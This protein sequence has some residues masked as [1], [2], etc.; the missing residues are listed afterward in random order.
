M[1]LYS[2]QRSRIGRKIKMS[3]MDF[4]ARLIPLQKGGK[5]PAR[6]FANH[7]FTKDEINNFIRHGYNVGLLAQPKFIF[8]DID[9][10]ENHKVDG[11]TNFANWCDDNEIDFES[12]LEKTLVQKT[13]TGGVHMIFLKPDGYDFH[14]DIGFI[15]GVDIKASRNNYIVI[16][17]SKTADGKYEF[18]D[19]KQ[20][21]AILPAT[22]AKAIQKRSKA[23][24]RLQ[25]QVV[26]GEETETGLMYRNTYTKYPVL[27]VFYTMKNGF[28]NKG[29]RNDN[30]FK[31]SQQIRKL[32]D[33]E[34]ALE[35]AKIANEH[36]QVPI[37][38]E[39]LQHTIDS[40]FS[41][42]E[43][44]EE[45]TTKENGKSWVKVQSKMSTDH[46]AVLKSRYDEV[47]SRWKKDY[48]PGDLYLYGSEWKDAPS[49][50]YHTVYNY[51]D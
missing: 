6:K 45:F 46:Y 51:H 22:L 34:T 31:W 42:A 24:R 20:N 44:V 38:S 43:E 19:P 28:G 12:L 48:D 37:N 11:I 16:A 8:I 14:Q 32:T 23:Q 27:D 25:Q 9:T 4:G 17:P 49:F 26:T 33:K 1:D 39:E 2:K 47:G 21:P 29:T 15:D 36:T 3:L 13:P 30:L 50:K 10:P 41:F 7:D 40:A 5:R 35:C 18:F